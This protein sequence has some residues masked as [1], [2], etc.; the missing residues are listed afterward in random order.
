MYKHDLNYSLSVQDCKSLQ[1]LNGTNGNALLIILLCMLKTKYV[2]DYHNT[3]FD[4]TVFRTR[5]NDMKEIFCNSSVLQQDTIK[6]LLFTV[7]RFQK[8]I[9]KCWINCCPHNILPTVITVNGTKCAARNLLH[10]FNT[11]VVAQKYG[12]ESVRKNSILL[13][14][15]CRVL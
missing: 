3:M 1:A 15:A 13:L 9:V 14:Y 4:K 6:M 5:S 12:P 7:L 8:G 11:T 10:P 2:T